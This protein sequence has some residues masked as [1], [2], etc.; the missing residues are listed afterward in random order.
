M[1]E[2]AAVTGVISGYRTSADGTIRITI[3][4]NELETVQFQERFV[5]ILKGTTVVV[6]RMT[7]ATTEIP[8]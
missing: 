2:S 1:T 8:G 7:D 3:D 6:A 4:L 5:G